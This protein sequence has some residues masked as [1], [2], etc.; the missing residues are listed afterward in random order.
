M[1][2]RGWPW[3]QPGSGPYGHLRWCACSFPAGGGQLAGA[4]GA[5]GCLQGNVGE[6]SGTGL[7]R[8]R[9]RGGGKAEAVDHHVYRLDD[10]E[11]HGGADDE[12]GEHRLMKSP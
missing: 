6:A 11:E 8:W 12:Q 7:G 4:V 9:V 2:V 5:A 10:Q 3:S 1:L